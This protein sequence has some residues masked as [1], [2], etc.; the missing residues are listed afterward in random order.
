METNENQKKQPE[1]K[2]RAGAVSATI[3]QNKGKSADGQE[4]EYPSV[5]FERSYK[6]KTGNWKTS[7]S[8]HTGDL[9][10]AVVVLN[11]AYEYL[12][13]KGREAEA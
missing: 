10:K 1:R 13:M 12:S 6:D 5:L 9:P 2:F 7:N 8:L 11:K 4:V 3:W